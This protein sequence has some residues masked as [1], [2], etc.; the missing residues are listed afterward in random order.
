[1]EKEGINKQL[2]IILASNTKSAVSS[3]ELLK[4]LQKSEIEIDTAKE[5][6][7]LYKM[8]LTHNENLLLLGLL[9]EKP[10]LGRTAGE[11][12]RESFKALR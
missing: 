5:C 9:N 10:N 3:L 2:K 6:P 11:E 8:F 4:L 1:V 12:S 7:I